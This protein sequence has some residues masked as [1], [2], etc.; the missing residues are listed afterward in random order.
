[1]TGV[2]SR[3]ENRFAGRRDARLG[4]RALIE[5]DPTNKERPVL[6][7]QIQTHRPAVR[8]IDRVLPAR[9]GEQVRLVVLAI[10]REIVA[11]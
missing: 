9:L 5:V 3:E 11:R 6:I 2:R 10:A 4:P 7:R 8:R 1:M